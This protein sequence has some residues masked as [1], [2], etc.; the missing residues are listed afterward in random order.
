M[1][2]DYWEW[3]SGIEF[4]LEIHLEIG[5]EIADSYKEHLPNL[6]P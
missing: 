6:F 1:M 5:P 2:M 4:G 3:D